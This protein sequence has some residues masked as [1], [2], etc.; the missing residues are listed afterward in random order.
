VMLMWFATV[1]SWRLKTTRFLMLL[2]FSAAV[3]WTVTL[4]QFLVLK[5]PFLP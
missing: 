3:Y 4:V 1:P 2:G 5:T